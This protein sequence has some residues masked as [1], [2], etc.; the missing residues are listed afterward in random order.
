MRSDVFKSNKELLSTVCEIANKRALELKNNVQTAEIISWRYNLR[1]SQVQNWLIETNWN[2]QNKL[3]KEPFQLVIEY[4]LKL[5]LIEKGE[6]E[7]WK[8]KLF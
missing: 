7:D 3:E 1:L 4:L 8:E 5:N 2:Y 6:A